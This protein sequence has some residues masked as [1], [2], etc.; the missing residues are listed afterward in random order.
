MR[1]SQFLAFLTLVLMGF[2]VA[3]ATVCAEPSVDLAVLRRQLER[4][5]LK[6]EGPNF[7]KWGAEYHVDPRLIVAIAGAETTYGK[8]LCGKNNA[9]NW[10]W[11]GSCA[12]SEFDS[13]DQGI[14]TVS[15]FMRR[16]YFLAGYT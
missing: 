1:G 3:S 11:A 15:M 5:P 10:F 8:H 2:C 7:L 16:S 14:K 4:F 9:W 13:F 12:P 6:D